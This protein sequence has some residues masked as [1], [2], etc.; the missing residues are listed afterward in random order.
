MQFQAGELY[1]A[2][3]IQRHLEVGNAGGIRVSLDKTRVKRIALL[4]VVPTAKV[5]RENPYHDRIEGDVLVY[6]AGGLRGDQSL[7]GVNKRLATQREMHFPIYCF[8]LNESRRKAGARRWEF[9]A[10]LQF[11][12]VYPD[13]QIDRDGTLRRVWLFELRICIEF[14]KVPV[15]EE[16]ALTQAAFAGFNFD[17]ERESRTDTQQT[18]DASSEIRSNAEAIERVRAKI[19]ALD[20]RGFEL[21]VQHSLEAT[22]FVDV[23]VT[24]YT[25]DSGIDVNARVAPVQWP[26]AGMRV[27]LQAKRWLHTVGRREVAEL[28]GSLEPF[29]Q[30]AVVT[31]SFFSRAALSEAGANGRQPI[32]L[33][34]G[35]HFALTVKSSGL[36]VP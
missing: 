3:E 1:T 29:A 6:S 31:T 34:D 18:D 12:R 35:Y 30:G 26:I 19:F 23:S 10:L 5:E 21:L 20:P 15:A 32:A 8:R 7:G 13:T 16:Q 24:R 17:S 27:Q 33:I 36:I 2:V 22:G 25:Q 11:L 14:P 28:R 4:T 9:L